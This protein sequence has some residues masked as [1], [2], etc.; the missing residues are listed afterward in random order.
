MAPRELKSRFDQIVR[1]RSGDMRRGNR[2]IAVVETSSARGVVQPADTAS[3]AACDVVN[4]V[5]KRQ[6]LA[7][8]EMMIHLEEAVRG[9]PTGWILARAGAGSR[10]IHR[11]QCCIDLG[12]IRGR[13]GDETR[14][15]A[16]GL[17]EVAEEEIAIRT[18]RSAGRY[19]VLRLRQRIF[20]PGQRVPRI[21]ALIP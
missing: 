8:V 1:R 20:R 9:V 11:I 21:H 4:A 7:I 12:D 17:L 19:A 3:I 15:I 13:D 2:M 6:L 16:A 18:K 14:S 10:I 5:A